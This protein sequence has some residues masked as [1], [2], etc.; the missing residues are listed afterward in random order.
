MTRIATFVFAFML[1]VSGVATAQ[2]WADYQNNPDGFKITFPGPP[3]VSNITWT[4]EHGYPLPGHVYTFD[5]GREHYSVTVV[6]YRGI[7]K[8]AIEHVKTCPTGANICLGNENTGVGF[9]KHDVRGGTIYAS[10]SLM[11]RDAKLTDFVWSQHDRVEG[12]ELQLTNNAD[13]SRTY[14]YVAMH[15]MR[16]YIVEGTVPRNYP[17]ATL[18]QTSMSWVDAQGNPVSYQVPYIYANEIHGLGP[19]PAPPRTGQ[20]APARA[21][22]AAPQGAP[23]GGQRGGRAGRASQP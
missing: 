12:H 13:Q 8:L 23:A 2:E 16:L 1:S 11:K 15:D 3:T 18:F 6:D 10:H 19:T 21:G 4:S 20:A 5:R 7:E 17:P 9:W 14:A 22:G